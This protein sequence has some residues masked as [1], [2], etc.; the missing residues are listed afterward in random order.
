MVPMSVC[1]PHMASLQSGM[2][3]E[4]LVYI[5]FTLLV[6]THE[7]LNPSILY[8]SVL[9]HV[10]YILHIDPTLWHK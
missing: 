8:M 10:Y 9:L 6:Y 4:T 2:G 3:T 7:Q 5:H 1:I